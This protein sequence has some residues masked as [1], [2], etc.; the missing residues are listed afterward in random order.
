M[1]QVDRVMA[2]DFGAK[3]LGVAV[4]DLTGVLAQPV[5][6]IARSRIKED[7]VLLAKVIEEYAIKRIVVGNPRTLAGAEGSQSARVHE[8]IKV[9]KRTFNLPVDLYDERLSS[10]Q[11]MDRLADTG[12]RGRDAK[13]SVDKVAAALVLQAY[14]DRRRAGR[15]FR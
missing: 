13:A 11:A 10:K 8:F 2:I 9:L 3:R 4:S 12:I 14:L 15:A 6:V 5:T 7:L 1:K